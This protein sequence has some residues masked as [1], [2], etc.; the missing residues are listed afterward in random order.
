VV[1]EY[2]RPGDIVILTDSHTPTAGVLNT[3]AFGVGST[4]MAFAF[5]TGSFRSPCRRPCGSS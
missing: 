2:A 5:R 1:E 4:A 3:F